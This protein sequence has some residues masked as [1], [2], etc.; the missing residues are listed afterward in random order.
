MMKNI[1]T[2]NKWV[3][4]G[5][6]LDEDVHFSTTYLRMS[7]NENIKHIFQGYTAFVA[8]YDNFNEEYFFDED[9]CIEI[10]RNLIAKII[11]DGPWFDQ[12][13]DNVIK[14]ADILSGIFNEQEMGYDF[15]KKRSNDELKGLY[16]KQLDAT[17]ALYEYARI[18]EILDRGVNYFTDFL[19][20]YLKQMLNKNEVYEEFRLLTKA[21]E[22]SIYQ[23]ADDDLKKIVEM[24]PQELL[25]NP[26]VRNLRLGLPLNVRNK[27]TDFLQKWKYLEYHGYGL[28]KILNFEDVLLKI[29]DYKKHNISQLINDESDRG[30]ISINE[31]EMPLNIRKLFELYPKLAI[32][33]L[34][35]KY[36]QIKNFYFLDMILSE[37]AS[38][39][40]ETEAFV[41][42]MLPEEILCFFETGVIE[43]EKIKARIGGCI[44]SYYDNKEFI[45]TDKAEISNI[46]KCLIQQ[47]QNEELTTLSGYPVS[48][49]LKTGKCVIVNRR[50]DVQKFQEGNIIISDS[51]DP[52]IFDIVQQAGAVLTVQGGATSHVA[53]FCREQ[54]VPAII[55]I[56]DLMQIKDGTNV[57]V[58]AY[59]GKVTILFNDTT[60]DFFDIGQKAKN[61]HILQEKNFLVP[62]F[63][64]LNYFE[65][66]KE[67]KLS[68]KEK[69][70]ERIH[71]C[72]MELSENKKYIFRSSAINEDTIEQSNVGKFTSITNLKRGELLEGIE[73]FV[74]ENDKKGYEG[75][76]IF[77][78]MLP[79]DFCGVAITG[80][81][82]LND[83]NFVTLEVCKGDQNKVTE[84]IG[85][86]SRIIYDKVR[87]EINDYTSMESIFP[88][89]QVINLV[90]SFLKIEKVW[91]KPVDIEWGVLHDVLYILQV[92]PIV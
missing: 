24:I 63:S 35:R 86:I 36:Y 12:I 11:S 81:G 16:K 85:K 61:L 21:S 70:L 43:R 2:E 27:I 8:I 23:K 19:L 44:Y 62:N 28:K 82:R 10:A 14:K 92:R 79:F 37:I 89:L 31:N 64:V 57:E 65:I 3:S 59:Q 75:G 13:L 33:K 78:E 6:N 68:K 1:R 40:Q 84:G 80:D 55:G 15:L 54:G 25:I 56:K 87:D 66:R 71:K 77:Q 7:L 58:N 45:V 26:T 73:R 74:N 42:C 5:I 69:V 90:N 29:V 9:E 49:G 30:S 50:E 67:L 52:D 4:C 53:L 51:A 46:K 41:R 38:R 48:K 18:P 88:N 60:E 34:Y 72:G 39:I 22:K 83:K 91:N 17:L 47:H 20:N 76:I 32:T